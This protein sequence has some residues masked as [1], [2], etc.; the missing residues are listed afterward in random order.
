MVSYLGLVSKSYEVVG[1]TGLPFI[2]V[3]GRLEADIFLVFKCT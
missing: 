3:V 2:R 1:R